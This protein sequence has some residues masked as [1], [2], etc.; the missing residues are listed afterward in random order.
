MS[1]VFPPDTT[2]AWA[3]IHTGLNPASHGIINFVNIADKKGSYVPFKIRDEL[4]KGKTFWDVASKNG[5]KVCIVLPQNI[6]P[7]WEVNG[8][9]VCR[10]N[11]VDDDDHPLCRPL[12]DGFPRRLGTTTTAGKETYNHVG[13]DIRHES[14]R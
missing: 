5:K 2:P 10:T 7:G 9:L 13:R 3:T 4:S 14:K 1:S 6:Y 12:L 11:R 8:C